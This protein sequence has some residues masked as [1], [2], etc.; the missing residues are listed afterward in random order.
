MVR[1]SFSSWSIVLVMACLAGFIGCTK[2]N[3]SDVKRIILLN[4]NESP[5]W[6]AATRAFRQ[7]KR[8]F[9]SRTPVSLP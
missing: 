5:Y 3:K 8:N 9:T 4:N 1:K 6:N 7:P 2:N